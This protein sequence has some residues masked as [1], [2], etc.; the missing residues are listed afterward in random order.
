MITNMFLIFLGMLIGAFIGVYCALLCMLHIEHL[1]A[2]AHRR[3]QKRRDKTQA[4]AEKKTGAESC[5][6]G[7]TD[8]GA[9]SGAEQES[10]AGT[11]TEEVPCK[12]S[13]VASVAA[14]EGDSKD[15][16]SDMT[17]ETKGTLSA[18]CG[19]TFAPEIKGKMKGQDSH[20][21]FLSGKRMDAHTSG[22][23]EEKTESD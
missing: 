19:A 17:E 3:R 7:V 20:Y 16:I 12:T 22:G 11:G 13:G 21:C 10:T 18:A 9:D 6:E 5:T 1:E 14:T 23:T 2:W 8:S 4:E 15:G